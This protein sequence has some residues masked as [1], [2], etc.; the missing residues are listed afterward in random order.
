MM[1]Y[2]EKTLLINFCPISVVS[3]AVFGNTA[4]VIVLFSHQSEFTVPKFLMLNLAMADLCMGLYLMLV[5]IQD[6][7][8]MGEYFNFAFVWQYGEAEFS[9]NYVS[10]N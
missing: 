9:L 6:L 8:S 3:L 7:R 5:A 4:V 2:C 10:V 1:I